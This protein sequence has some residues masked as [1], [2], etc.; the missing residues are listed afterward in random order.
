MPKATPK[1]LTKATIHQRV[2]E[3]SF[4]LAQDYVQNEAIFD[5]R[6]VSDAGQD[7]FT[8]GCHL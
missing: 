7:H 4:K 3:R 5:A 6:R 1:P 2:G 8:A